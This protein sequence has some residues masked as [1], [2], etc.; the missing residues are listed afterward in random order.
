MTTSTSETSSRNTPKPRLGARGRVCFAA[1]H[2]RSAEK[3]HSQS[4][5]RGPRG[6]TI[7]SG[8]GANCT[9]KQKQP[10]PEKAPTPRQKQASPE[11]GGAAANWRP[12]QQTSRSRT[13][14]ERL[15][16]TW[17]IVSSPRRQREGDPKPYDCFTVQD[18]KRRQL[19]FP[20][21]RP[22]SAATRT[23]TSALP[24]RADRRWRHVVERRP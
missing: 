19:F 16:S 22:A 17:P 8:R 14:S 2:E 18:R 1:M 5:S 10:R 4:N 20:R 12:G 7:R 13:P 9:G 6:G 3:R 15:L 11:A 23:F 21:Q 24:L